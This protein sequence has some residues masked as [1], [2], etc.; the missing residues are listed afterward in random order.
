MK[1]SLLVLR[2]TDIEQSKEFYSTIGMAFVRE[3]HGAG[4]EHYAFEKDGFVFELY[5][6]KP[7]NT[8]VGFNVDSLE[9]TVDS[10]TTRGYEVRRT[11]K[12][13][14]AKDPDGRTVELTEIYIKPNCI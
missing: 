3:Q 6:G 14:L 13:A 9:R 11:S 2:C 12:R 1:L 4:P 7:D 8:R 5:P 10:L